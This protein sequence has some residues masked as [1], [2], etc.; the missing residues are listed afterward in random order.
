MSTRHATLKQLRLFETVARLGSYTQAARDL[1]LTQPAV[2]IQM[3]N[4]EGFVGLPLFEQVGKTLG[5]TEGGRVLLDHARAVLEEMESLQSAVDRLKGLKTGRLRISSVTTVNY[6][7][8]A[9]LR[10]FCERYPGITVAMGVANRQELLDELA[11]NTIDMAIMGRPPA[12][13]ELDAEPFLDNPL[14]IVAPPDH[15]LARRKSV[16]LGMLADQ[17]FL[18]REPGSGTRGAM[19][20]YFAEKGIAITASIEV[21]GAEALKQGV[22]A[23]LGLAMMSRDAVELEV[24]SG[25]LVELK[26]PGLPIHRKWF[27]VHRRNKRLSPSAEAFK[28]FIA[29]EAASLLGRKR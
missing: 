26:V 12:G 19:E 13:S 29:G 15:P 8:P 28:A 18:M 20:R 23:G 21:S 14:V 5:L 2:S 25:R 4:L 17:V 7:A 6:F 22:Q 16:P 10:T 27:L 3:K 11:A 9:L 1:H 24:A